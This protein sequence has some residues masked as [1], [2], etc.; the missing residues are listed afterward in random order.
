MKNV[1]QMIVVLTV[2]AVIS[3]IAL[4]EIASWANPKIAIN[5]AKETEKAI[6][7]VQPKAKSY[8]QIKNIDFELYQVFD[9]NNNPIG[10]AFPYEGNGFQGKIRLIVGLNDSLNV[11]SRVEI[12]EQVETPGLGTKITEEPFLK[13]FENLVTF[14]QIEWIKGS[15][16]TKSNQIQTIT[17]ATISSKSVVEILNNGINKL[18]ELKQKGV[19]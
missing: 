4:S 13:Q 18:R 7:R 15:K 6:F 19:I 17:A 2:I 9:Q 10:Y 12:L 1:I 8:K 16:P 5:R 14:P 3:G 11:I